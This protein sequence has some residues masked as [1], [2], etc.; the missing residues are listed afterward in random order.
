MTVMYKLGHFEGPLDLLLHLIDQAEIDIQHIS[1]SE[2][3]V[4]YMAYLR[5]MQKLE[6]EITSE[7][8]VMATTLLS[9]KSQQLL[10]K[11]PVIQ[12]IENN[13]DDE[14]DLNSQAELIRKLLAYRKYKRI[15]EHLREHEAKRNMIFLKEPENLTPFMLTVPHTLPDGLH[16]S[17]L[18]D[19]FCKVLSKALRR[20]QVVTIQQDE[21]SIKERIVG[22]IDTLRPLGKGGKVMFSYLL[23]EHFT[24]LELVVFFLAL[25]ELMKRKQ[26]YC[27][28]DN[29]FADIV[30]QWSGEGSEDGLA[31]VEADY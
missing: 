28:Q 11:P 12:W 17:D 1:I 8:L 25:L 19:A 21:I 31:N 5:G 6:L 27:Y 2:I 13:I 18:I 9:M 20:A 10:P 16:V 30:I 3:T 7:F 23:G 26:V 24:R 15:A 14:P 4:Q 29:L 22:I